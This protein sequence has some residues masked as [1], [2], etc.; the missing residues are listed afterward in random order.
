[1][2]R[3]MFGI[4]A[5]KGQVLIAQGSAQGIKVV[6]LFPRIL[7]L[8]WNSLPRWGVFLEIIKLRNE[9]TNAKP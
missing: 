2:M 4:S 9:V 1:M 3:N 7:I 6:V 5:L 8:V